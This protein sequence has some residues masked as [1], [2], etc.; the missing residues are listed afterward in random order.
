MYVQLPCAMELE[1]HMMYILDE[2]EI[3]AL[4]AI[5]EK[6]QK[7]IKRSLITKGTDKLLEKSKEV[8][9]QEWQ[10]FLSHKK[11]LIASAQVWQKVMEM[12]ASGFTALQE[13]GSKYSIREADIIKRM[14]KIH[15]N[16]DSLDDF[17][18]IRSYDIEKVINTN[19]WKLYVQNI[20]QA[21]P[22][23]FAGMAGLPFNIVLAT[24]LQFR[25]VQLI[26]MHYGYD[27][28]NSQ[29]E[30]EYASSVYLQI[31]SKGQI[32]DLDGYGEI[33][34]KMMA[35]AE[36]HSLRGA[37]K[38]KTYKKMAEAKGIYLI[39][40]QMRAITN[41]AAAKALDSAGQKGIENKA[42]A[43]ILEALSKKMGQQAGAKYIP[44]VS[45]MLSVLIDTHQINKVIKGA[46]LIYHKRFLLDKEM[47]N[48]PDFTHENVL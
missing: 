17:F 21:A 38:T 34:A 29:T 35:Q 26:A 31:I 33:I 5:D 2:K 45:A 44:F 14:N 9:P 12:A 3:R 30:M 8:V 20:L 41:K 10:D 28:K 36:L 13:V 15:Y 11:D 16:V 23:G 42:L 19:D 37:L 27:V 1:V 18:Q 32:S 47:L 40:V 39:Y 7:F 6:Y 25:T 22:T 48:H 24:F 46:N 4:E 43:K